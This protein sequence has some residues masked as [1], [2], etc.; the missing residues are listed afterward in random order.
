MNKYKKNSKKIQNYK[1]FG[2]LI[3]QKY[4]KKALLINKQKFDI[5][6]YWL[7]TSVN[8]YLKDNII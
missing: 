1:N 3:I 4:I 5:R 8:L 7:I 2:S 6:C